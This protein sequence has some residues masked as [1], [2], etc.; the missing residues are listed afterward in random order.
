MPRKTETGTTVSGRDGRS[1]PSDGVRKPAYTPWNYLKQRKGQQGASATGQGSPTYYAYQPALWNWAGYGW[2]GFGWNSWYLT[3]LGFCDPFS[4]PTL[5]GNPLCFNPSG[6][7]YGYD[8]FLFNFGMSSYNTFSPYYWGYDCLFCSSLSLNPFTVGMPD[9]FQ[10]YPYVETP[11]SSSITGGSGSLK[12]LVS[13]PGSGDA[14][15]AAPG[16]KLS[17]YAYATPPLPKTPVTL[18]LT[19]GTKVEATQYRLAADGSLHYRTTTGAQV[20]IP[21]KRL[22]MKATMKANRGKGVNFL[23]PVAESKPTTKPQ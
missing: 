4:F 14:S 9:S 22:N 16:G 21:F 13:A 7:G 10:L 6:Y 20:T 11:G 17:T 8:P 23:A 2:G 19:D 1:L 12:G 18:V 3:N 5:Y 15:L